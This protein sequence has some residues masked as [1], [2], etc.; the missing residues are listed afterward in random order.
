M[1]ERSGPDLS[2]DPEI[3]PTT[4]VSRASEPLTKS[5]KPAR[6]QERL[7][8]LMSGMLIALTAFFFLATF[9]QMSYLHWSILDS[10][11]IQIEPAS[12]E[13]SYVSSSSFD[14]QYEARQFEVRAAMERYI[15]E[16]RYHQVSVLL[17]SGLWLRYLG[18]ITGMILALVGASFILGKL[19]EPEQEIKGNFSEISL[20]VRTASPGIILAVLGVILMFA[21][22]VDRDVYNVKDANVYLSVVS[23]LDTPAL[24]PGDKLPP[25]KEYFDTS[26]L[27]GSTQLTPTPG[28]TSNAGNIPAMNLPGSSGSEP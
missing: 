20:S 25:L 22:I 17:M 19:R 28:K 2:I 15:I 3:P 21:T 7:L 4:L 13:A 18:F 10:P 1:E 27:P 23:P 9:V 16:K 11:P 24:G 12:S 8:P 5:R 26:D 14:Q 6:W